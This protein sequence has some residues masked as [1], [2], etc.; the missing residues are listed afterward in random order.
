MVQTEILVIFALIEWASFRSAMGADTQ[1]IMILV[2]ILAVMTS[3]FMIIAFFLRFQGAMNR[4]ME[5]VRR[6]EAGVSGAE[7]EG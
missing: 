3:P 6:A 1:A 5:A 7:A 4:G 2:L